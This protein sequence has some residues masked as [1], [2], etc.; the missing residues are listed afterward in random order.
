MSSGVSKVAGVDVCIDSYVN[1]SVSRSF[2]VMFG[3]LIP[4]EVFT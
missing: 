3:F 2:K 1:S 4:S